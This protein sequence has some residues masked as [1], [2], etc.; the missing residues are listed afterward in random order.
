MESME[1]LKQIKQEVKC[2]KCSHE[3]Q[4]ADN[5]HSQDLGS[6]VTQVL[7]ICPNCDESKHCYF[8][9][10]NTIVSR[11]KLNAAMVRFQNSPK[12]SRN[13]RWQQFQFQKEVYQRIF[14]K[15]QEACRKRFKIAQPTGATE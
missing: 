7:I 4:L 10:M 13:V 5:L 2:E 8:D 6:G 14:Q 3:F 9:T 1:Q 12:S 11:G 15:E